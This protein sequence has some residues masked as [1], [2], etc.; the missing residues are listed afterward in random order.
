MLM[1]KKEIKNILM[2]MRVP[3]NENTV[4]YLLGKIDTKEDSISIKKL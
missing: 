3:D 4:N 1:T 2:S